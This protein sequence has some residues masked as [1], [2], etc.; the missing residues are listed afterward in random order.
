[1]RATVTPASPSAVLPLR[2]RYRREMN[3]Q[4]VHDS[5][6]RRAGWTSTYLLRLDDTTAG[7]GS[8]AIGG[9]WTGK[10]T[11]FEFYVV[12]AHRGRAFDLFEA[13]LEASGSRLMEIQ[14]NDAL[15]AV[16]LHTY[17]RE[18]WSEK[19]VFHDGVTTALMA[20]GAV[21]QQVT[22]GATT[23]SIARLV[24]SQSIRPVGA[25]L[26]V[27]AGSAAGLAALLLATPAAAS[28]G[29]IVHV[30]DPAAYAVSVL[31]IVAACL[32]AASIPAA[33]AARLDP[34]RTL[35]QE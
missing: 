9:P 28:I 2:V 3:C 5:I 7:F 16:M 24:L 17:A 29:E 4:V 23:Q 19:I 27:G 30:L 12:P 32:V 6:H 26:F 21:L 1:M 18:I 11:I 31:V 14:S 15:L 33:R 25:G 8:V 10:P 13:F 22:P 20:N 34:A 35:R